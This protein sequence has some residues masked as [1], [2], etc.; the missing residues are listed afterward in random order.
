MGE[1]QRRRRLGPITAQSTH[2]AR[3]CRAQYKPCPTREFANLSRS[4]T[5]ARILEGH[6]GL[7]SV[8]LGVNCYDERGTHQDACRA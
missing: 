2:H 3:S 5:S 4:I 8:I 7:E 1:L 6:G